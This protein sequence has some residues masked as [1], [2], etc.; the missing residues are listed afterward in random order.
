MHAA[1]L[2]IGIEEE[3]QLINPE[4]GAA[5]AGCAGAAAYDESA[6]CR[7]ASK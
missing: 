2:T 5:S 7:S 1:P 6:C 3:Y 4:T